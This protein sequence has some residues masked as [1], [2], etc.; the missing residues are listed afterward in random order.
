MM[1]FPQD[2]NFAQVTV[3]DTELRQEVRVINSG[4][5]DLSFTAA[6]HSYF[7]VGDIAQVRPPPC[8]PGSASWTVCAAL[9]SG[10]RGLDG[11]CYK[12]EAQGD[13]VK[14]QPAAAAPCQRQQQH[15]L[16]SELSHGPLGSLDT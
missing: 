7:R 6:L 5:R 9:Q 12:L 3:R 11:C 10:H 14:Q 1:R 2:S 13:S 15:P 4:E 8:M 16:S